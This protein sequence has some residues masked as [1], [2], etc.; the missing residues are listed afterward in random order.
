MKKPHVKKCW[1]PDKVCEHR[2]NCENPESSWDR[3]CRNTQRLRSWV[4]CP[5]DIIENPLYKDGLLGQQKALDQ[6]RE[7]MLEKRS[8]VSLRN[9]H[10]KNR[11]REVS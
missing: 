1:H 9:K 3:I 11:I 7:K 6:A 10:G 5:Y 2:I 8:R 4:P